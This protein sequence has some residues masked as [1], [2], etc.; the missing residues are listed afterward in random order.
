MKKT[1][2]IHIGGRHFFM[3]EDAY[4]KLSHYL[5]ALK[6]HFSTDGETGKEI[7][8]DIEQRIAELLKNKV[9]NGKQA[10][11]LEDINEMIGV[12]GKVED[13][14]YDG[15]DEEN[16][17]GYDYYNR[18]DY[19][20]F[21]RDP[22]NYYLG[23]VASGMG[24]Y[25]NIDPL[26]IR[27]AF[28][29]LVILKGA[30]VLI[31][32]ILWLVVPKARTTTEKLQM[33]GKPV[34]LSTIKDSVNEEYEKVKTGYDRISHSQAADRT[35]N[36]LENLMRAIGLVMLA[37]FKFTIGAVGVFFLVL[38]SIFLAGFIMVI[39]GFTNIFGHNQLWNGIYLP[40][41]AHFFTN[42]GHYYLTVIA[43][44]ILV[45][46]P[47]I[48]LIY[49]GVKILFNIKT[50]HPILRAFLLAAWILAFILF[51]ALVI[52][53]VPNSSVEATGSQT[54]VI[55]TNK[56]PRLIIDVR[57]NTENK[58]ITH[59]WVMGYKFNYC[60]WD[61]ELYDNAEL[62]VE[63][64]EDANVHLNIQKSI[65]NVDMKNAQRYFDRIDYK[66]EQKDSVLYLDQ[67]FSNDDDD[68]WMF[69]SVDLRLRIPEGQE[70]VITQE[71]CDLLE[72]DLR[73]QYCD[74]QS[75]VGK[76]CLLSPEGTLVPV[77]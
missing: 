10:V 28:V 54:T 45:L 21:Y 43:L 19:R 12:L 73:F 57:D 76:R 53:N 11:T 66:W 63:R 77:K 17:Q 3:D 7:V 62:S 29:A 51:V 27:L 34:N 65:K 39:L 42:S 31:Y 18:K 13:F 14:I 40:D 22:D 72:P 60:D 74:E 24:A 69:A 5:G 64:S 44:V 55:E 35:R 48:A 46:I 25:L 41:V 38:G 32:L 2:Q 1:T 58:R 20:R 68:F 15:E 4:Q 23:G 37:V 26:W 67:Y 56:Y 59:Y 9:T 47:I 61:E 16:R 52:V 50:K 8:E 36:A 30:G 75:L 71:A 70:I 49:G 33:R 6:S